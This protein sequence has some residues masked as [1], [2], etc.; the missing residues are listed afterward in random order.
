MRRLKNCRVCR[1][2]TRMEL[3]MDLGTQY[4]S[5]IFPAPGEDVEKGPL[6]L[7]R[8]D[9]CG[10]IQLGHEPDLGMLYGPTYGYRSGLNQSMVTH[11]REKVHKLIVRAN[12]T[13][14][15]VVMDIGSSDG[16][17]LK[18]WHDVRPG[19]CTVGFDPQ[20][21]KFKEHYHKDTL[22]FSQFFDAET[23]VG[24]V[25][26]KAKVITAVAMFYDLENPVDFLRQMAAC[27]MPDGII[28]MEFAYLGTM[29]NR[30]SFDTICHEHLEYYGLNQIQQIAKEAGL[31]I[32]EL[33]F[34]DVNGG[35]VEVDL[36]HRGEQDD[37]LDIVWKCKNEDLVITDKEWDKF[38]LHCYETRAAINRFLA[39]VDQ[40]EVA[41]LGASTKGNVLLQFCGVTK[42]DVHAAVDVNEEKWGKVTPGTNIPIISEE[43]ARENKYQY[44]LVLPWHFRAGIIA[45]EEEFLNR[46]GKLIFPLPEFEIVTK[47]HEAQT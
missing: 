36:V 33:W 40:R 6:Q 12:V 43:E 26:V 27:L 39:E 14:N 38:K 32:K 47:N 28:H 10:L 15:D 19:I 16:T 23:Y 21:E 37:S 5:G 29:I 22:A 18:A 4:L 3:M 25:G 20:A 30:G 45:R 13:G 44:Y 17:L 11:L 42:D 41:I 9:S 2:A 35:S 34:N 7:V 31:L 1:R 46:G 24:E 8:C